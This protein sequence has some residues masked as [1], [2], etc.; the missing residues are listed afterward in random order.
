MHLCPFSSSFLPKIPYIYT[1]KLNV[2][3]LPN[4]VYDGRSIKG[5][6]AVVRACDGRRTTPYT[7]KS[8]SSCY[9]TQ[10]PINPK[11]TSKTTKLTLSPTATIGTIQN[12]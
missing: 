11:G 2:R 3:R 4:N 1:L 10:K 8:L 7:S 12:K 6:M 9:S 5:M